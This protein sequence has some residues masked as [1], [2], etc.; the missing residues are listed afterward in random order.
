MAVNLQQHSMHR[1]SKCTILTVASFVA[2]GRNSAVSERLWCGRRLQNYCNELTPRRCGEVR[3][4]SLDENLTVKLLAEEKKEKVS[5]GTQR[6]RSLSRPPQYS[7]CRS[8]ASTGVSVATAGHRSSCERKSV[9]ISRQCSPI[10]V[11]VVETLPLLLKFEYRMWL[12][13]F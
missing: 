5:Q 6:L 2:V 11:N 4:E 8:A 9:N 10:K 13:C 7:E 12:F 1:V 3:P